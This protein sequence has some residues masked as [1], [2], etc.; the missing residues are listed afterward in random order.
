MTR[1]LALKNYLIN[2][3]KRIDI[4][5]LFAETANRLQNEKNI[6]TLKKEQTISSL[7]LDSLLIMEI[8]GDIQD[9]LDISL[10]DDELSQA[11]TI[12]ELESLIIKNLKQ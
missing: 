1:V 3:V 5:K 12:G 10:S 9:E 7:G 8:V 4:L 11:Q 2:I 6:E